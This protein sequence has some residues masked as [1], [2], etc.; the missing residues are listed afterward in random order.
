MPQIRYVGPFT[1]VSL[2]SL[3]LE[4]MPGET[5]EVDEESFANLCEQTDFESADTAYTPPV[6]TPVVDVPVEA[7][8]EPE[9]TPEPTPEPASAPADENGETP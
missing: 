5:V 9:P 2:P 3:G 4:M 1:P 6:V 7:T 8:P